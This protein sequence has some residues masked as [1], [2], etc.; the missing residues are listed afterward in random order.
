MQPLVLPVLGPI[1]GGILAGLA[2]LAVEITIARIF[3]LIKPMKKN[4]ILILGM[5]GAGKTVLFKRL[6]GIPCEKGEYTSTSDPI[7]KSVDINGRR[8]KLIDYPGM[9]EEQVNSK[10]EAHIKKN[11]FIYLLLD[12]M[13]VDDD[14]DEGDTYR[15]KFRARMDTIVGVMQKLKGCGLHIIATHFDEYLSAHPNAS[16]KSAK[17][18][19]YNKFEFGSLIDTQNKRAKEKCEKNFVDDRIT[20]VSLFNDEDIRKIKDELTIKK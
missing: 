5:D 10:Y 13:C 3:G 7:E 2:T 4:S 19:L 11:T 12:I 20:I 17:V 15:R 8:V 18:A 14:S 6:Q 1:A 9:E 16:K